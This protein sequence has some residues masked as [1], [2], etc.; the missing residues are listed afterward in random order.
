MDL[1]LEIKEMNVA[2]NIIYF[3][4][5]FKVLYMSLGTYFLTMKISNYKNN[6]IKT[7]IFTIA[8]I[9]LINLIGIIIGYLMK[10]DMQI[11]IIAIL[12]PYIISKITHRNI[13]YCVIVAVIALSINYVILFI[14]TALSFIF[15]NIFGIN[16]IYTCFIVIMMFY[17]IILGLFSKIKRIKNGLAFLQ[18][19]KLNDYTDMVILN[20]SIIVLFFAI[21]FNVYDESITDKI[22]YALIIFSI[23]MFITIQKSLQIYYKQKLLVQELEE[24]KNELEKKNKEIKELEQENL[25]FSKTSHTLA[26]KQKALEYKLNQLI[27]QSAKNEPTK[28]NTNASREDNITHQANKPEN[29]ETEQIQ[30]IK[31]RLAEISKDLYQNE[32]STRLAQTGIKRID[33]MLKYMQSESEKYNIKLELQITGNIHHMTNKI[34]EEKDLETLIADHVKNAIIAINHSKNENK[35]ILVKLGKIEENYG[36][37]I[38]DTGIEFEKETLE[39]LGKKPST[40][41]A[42][43]GGTGMGFMNTFDTINKY[44]ASLIINEIGKE[45]ETNYTKA[46]II[47]FDQKNEFK[48]DSY[49]QQKSTHTVKQ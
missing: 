27:N 32:K 9:I 1:M 38:Y 36:L 44:K 28:N 49:R 35:S 11:I 31:E 22:G 18:K 46:I 15:I 4:N 48:I 17:I 21:I 13:S 30:D 29:I 24:T 12:L 47:K 42:E 20:I 8:S 3:L 14:A 19:A 16:N 25:N 2:E 33:D 37:A 41:H 40:T 23:I 34:I 5:S 26:H 7:E 6:F 45:S 10:F 39:N 43:E